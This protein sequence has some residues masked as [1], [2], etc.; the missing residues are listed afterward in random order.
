MTDYTTLLSPS[1]GLSQ[2]EA[3]RLLSIYGRNELLDDYAP[4]RLQWMRKCLWG[5]MAVIVWA[6]VIIELSI[7]NWG[8]GGMLLL[9]QLMHACNVWYES[10]RPSSSHRRSGETAPSPSLV[11]R[12]GTW[13]MVP[14]CTLV[15]GDLVRLACGAAVPADCSVNDGALHVDES[16]LTG[17]PMPVVLRAQGIATY[18]SFVTCGE[19]EATVQ[20]TG[21]NTLFGRM[22][23]SL[24]PPEPPA[25]FATFSVS[26]RASLVLTVTSLVA[27]FICVGYFVWFFKLRPIFVVEFSVAVAMLLLP[28]GVAMATATTV[29]RSVR[30]LASKH[31][32]VKHLSAIETMAAVDV[33]LLNKSGTLTLNQL[34]VMEE[35]HVFEDGKDRAWLL[36][37]AALCS[38][39]QEVP[40][41]DALTEIILNSVDLANCS[42]CFTQLDYVPFSALHKRTEATV[43]DG[44]RS[45]FRVT[46]GSVHTVL[47]LCHNKDEIRVKVETL[48]TELTKRG[49]RCIAVAR[50]QKSED[51]EGAAKWRMSGV[52]QLMDPP[53]HD[54]K[55]TVSRLRECGVLVKMISGDHLLIA[56]EMARIL[57]MD[58]NIVTSAELPSS[59]F[60]ANGDLRDLPKTLGITHGDD[61]LACGGFAQVFPEHMYLIV[62]ILRQRG[63]TC[64]VVGYGVNM[65]SAVKHAHVGIAGP[66]ALDVIRDA[67]DIICLSDT[68]TAGVADL[69]SVSRGVCQRILA[70]LSYQ[71]VST[72]YLGLLLLIGMFVL[73]RKDYSGIAAEKVFSFAHEQVV[74]MMPLLALLNSAT[75]LAMSYDDVSPSSTRPQRCQLRV[76]FAVAAVQAIIACIASCLL[77]WAT[78][79]GAA[80][81]EDGNAGSWLDRL[82]IVSMEGLTPGHIVSMMALQ[83]PVTNVLTA[84]SVRAHNN[85]SFLWNAPSRPHGLVL[86]D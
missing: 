18:G 21:A 3:E 81:D 39:W 15:P 27:S 43:R 62:E 17:E 55:K 8:S 30:L 63:L 45:A 35:C 56:K 82:G 10:T 70:I 44:D 31:I 57:D 75:M 5:P 66:A 24:P 25:K 76:L 52:L 23:K 47:E 34:T 53:R 29:V 50:S 2:V 84:L 12:D 78:L 86:A 6:A 69:L 79:M 13:I 42:R 22:I 73:S 67:A 33:V 68:S 40:A 9:V 20:R 37:Q 51:Y 32:C 71:A 36:E 49:I 19:V 77:L 60:P 26:T 74:V 1:R 64:A 48:F 54:A 14:S 72:M 38:N 65:C 59:C 80:Q 83:V 11:Y 16:K 4:G 46:K 41:H 28:T 58:P 85:S 7:G 61:V